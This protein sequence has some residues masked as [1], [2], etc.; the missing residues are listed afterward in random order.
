MSSMNRGNFTSSVSI[1]RPSF[2]ASY[3]VGGT[4]SAVLNRSDKGGHPC[5][6]PL[7]R[8]RV[9][10]SPRGVTLVSVFQTSL[11]RLRTCLSVPRLMGVFIMSGWNLSGAFWCY[12][13][14]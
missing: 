13:L 7:L 1:S 8:E 2:P 12:M 14:R 5:L 6:F 4:S 9:H 3:S 11:I 10:V